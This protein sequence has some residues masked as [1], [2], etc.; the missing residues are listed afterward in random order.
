MTAHA[1]S[2]HAESRLVPAAVAAGNAV[3]IH[4]AKCA[5]FAALRIPVT[6]ETE[7]MP[8]IEPAV[9]GMAEGIVGV[10]CDHKKDL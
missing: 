3:V 5:E 6:G 2:P 1:I 7:M 8:G 10:D 4:H 9:I